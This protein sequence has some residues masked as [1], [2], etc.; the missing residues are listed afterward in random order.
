MVE[1]GVDRAGAPP[2]AGPDVLPGLSAA[3]LLTAL[4]SAACVVDA[5]GRVT[6]WNPA[7]EELT[8]IAAGAAIGARP[9][10]AAAQAPDPAEDPLAATLADGRPRQAHLALARPDGE[11]RPI[12][13]R[14]APLRDPSGRLLGAIV[15]LEPAD[16]GLPVLVDPVTGV[17]S[18]AAL[19]DR[20]QAVLGEFER[21]LS[22]SGILLVAVDDLPALAE[23]HG[24]A[25]GEAALR[26]VADALTVSARPSDSVGRW[27]SD[28]F[29][30]ILREVE[31]GDLVRVAERF[32]GLVERAA[33]EAGPGQEPLRVS[34]SFGA[35]LTG[36]DDT[37]DSIVGRARQA[38]DQAQ[39]QG[40]GQI[41]VVDAPPAPPLVTPPAPDPERVK[42]ALEHLV[43]D[44]KTPPA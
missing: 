1:P 4:P 35:T 33:V 14:T 15:L 24:L 28:A 41:V 26:A 16:P 3:D 37:I 10:P 6:A 11:S 31:A 21:Y 29:L 36:R 7:A 17:A 8:G 23:R 5:A 42:Q 12:A 32:R 18:R 30:V 20:L 27:E 13:V 39:G 22:P 38:L 44:V 9:W 34:A 2:P 25:A 19:A 40:R 43:Q